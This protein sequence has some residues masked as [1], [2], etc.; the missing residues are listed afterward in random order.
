[1]LCFRDKTFCTYYKDCVDQFDCG[2]ALTQQVKDDA[3]RWGLTLKMKN[4]PICMYTDKPECYNKVLT[5][6]GG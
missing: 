1:M 4:A 6:K 2:R 3:E 5:K